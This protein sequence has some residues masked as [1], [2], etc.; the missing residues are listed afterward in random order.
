MKSIIPSW[1]G[2]PQTVA[3]HF[4]SGRQRNR[5]LLLPLAVRLGGIVTLVHDEV[6]GSVVFTAGEV[7]VED[8]LDASS[9]SLIQVSKEITVLRVHW[10]HTFCASMDV[11][12]M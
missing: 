2:Q 6:L 11:P 8:G 12:D 4:L 5:L 9:I 7:G 10:G 1:R 3:V